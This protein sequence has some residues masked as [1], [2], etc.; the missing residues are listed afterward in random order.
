MSGAQGVRK[1][2]V[3]CTA[4]TPLVLDYDP[5]PAIVS[6]PPKEIDRPIVPPPQER[7]EKG[8]WLVPGILAG[9]G[10]VGLGVGFGLGSAAISSEKD[11]GNSVPTCTVTNPA[12]CSA[13]R[14]ADDR[15]TS[16]STGAVIGQVIGIAGLTGAVVSVLIIRPWEERPSA[17]RVTF[18]PG[19]GGGS[20]VGSF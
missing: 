12:G 9:V 4:G 1:A 11:A 19:F 3:V 10:V 5:K 18:V 7:M 20:I 16:L 8:S 15:A 14:D 6:P 2:N 17:T 13:L